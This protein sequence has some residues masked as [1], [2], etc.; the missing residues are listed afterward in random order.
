MKKHIVLLAALW[1]G[2]FSLPFLQAGCSTAPSQRV[3]TVQTLKIV[4]QSA[5]TSVDAAAQLLKQGS[6]TVEQW[7]KV[8]AL[9]DTNF[10]P[11]YGLAVTAAH[12]DLSTVASPDLVGIAAELATLVAQLTAK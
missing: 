10:Q 8:A 12:S 1:V 2:F 7:N 4:G 6:I 11:A 3:Q 9:Y 5:K